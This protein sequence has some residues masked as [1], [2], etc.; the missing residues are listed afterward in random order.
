VSH[1]VGSQRIK[2][3]AN[4][5]A[6]EGNIIVL[7]VER[8]P[9]AREIM[10]T[11]A[12]P[13]FRVLGVDVSAAN[14][15]TAV[16]ASD[17]LIHQGGRGYICVTG[18]HGVME[19][20]ADPRLREIHNR[21]FLTVPDGM[22]LVW[23]GKLLGHNAIGRVYGPDFMIELCRRSVDR[24]YSHF[25]YGGADGVA[26]DLK[27]ALE[28]KCPGIRI[29][30]T[31]TPPFRPL[32]KGEES[33]LRL[34]MEECK[35]DIVWVGLSTPKQERFM[36][37]SFPFLSGK[38]F[39]GVGAAFD[40]HTGRIQDSPA[41]FKVCGLQWFHRLCQEPRRLWRRYLFNNPR[42]V[43]SVARELFAMRARQ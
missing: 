14:M 41:L 17:Q 38:L 27:S 19:S 20:Q 2:L 8:P 1:R 37:E 29:V 36:A 35:P 43:Y 6:S 7:T 24:G 13:R 3:G 31:Y 12:Q 16:D 4:G 10:A 30:G 22:P 25:L 32:N 42:F 28:R 15:C 26:Q 18:V 23:L 9:E 11:T 34:Q 39:V 33:D 5:N 40:I 21:S